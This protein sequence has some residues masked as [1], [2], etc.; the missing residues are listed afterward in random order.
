M[1]VYAQQ[2]VLFLLIFARIAS[3]VITA[4]VFGHQSVPVQVKVAMGLFL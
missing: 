2:F 3:A 1:E 4:P